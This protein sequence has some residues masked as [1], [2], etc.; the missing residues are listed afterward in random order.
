MHCILIFP[1]KCSVFCCRIFYGLK[2]EILKCSKY[3]ISTGLFDKPGKQ[4]GL[5]QRYTHQ[6]DFITKYFDLH[7]KQISEISMVK[8]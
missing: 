7:L 5:L 4:Q 2:T 3:H 6:S 1:H 8:V